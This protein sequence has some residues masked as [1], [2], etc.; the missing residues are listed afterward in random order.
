MNDMA[1]SGNSFFFPQ[2]RVDDKR[3]PG[4]VQ[5]IGLN[6]SLGKVL[7]LSATGMRLACRARRALRVGETV[8][9]AL[10]Y[11]ESR[12]VTEARVAWVVRAGFRKRQMGME[13]VD[14]TDTETAKL[15]DIAR[16]SMANF[17]IVGSEA[18]AF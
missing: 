8:Q 10:T 3:R 4:R 18:D 16:M 9:V 14:L 7:D 13:F 15:R 5:C 2:K 6:C 12:L 1:S 11:G 17:T